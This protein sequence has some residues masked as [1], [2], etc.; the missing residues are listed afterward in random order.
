MIIYS[1]QRQ[2]L[3]ILKYDPSIVSYLRGPGCKKMHFL[4]TLYKSP[5]RM[6][7]HNA[8]HY[9]LIIIFVSDPVA[10]SVC[11]PSC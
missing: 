5:R 10:P 11:E 8:S 4:N 1:L 9:P 2:F 7:F 6:Y 3:N